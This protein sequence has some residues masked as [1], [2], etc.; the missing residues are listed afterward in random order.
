MALTRFLSV[1]IPHYE[2]KLSPLSTEFKLST[3]WIWGLLDNGW[4]RQGAVTAL[5]RGIVA[6]QIDIFPPSQETPGFGQKLTK[7]LHSE[8]IPIY[9]MLDGTQHL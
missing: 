4:E 1:K 7:V 3:F 9:F 2:C 6:M 5:S 8:G